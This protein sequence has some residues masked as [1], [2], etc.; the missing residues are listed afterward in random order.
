MQET[1]LLNCMLRTDVYP[2]IS[3][4]ERRALVR[5]IEGVGLKIGPITHSEIC[6]DFAFIKV[7]YDTDL[8]VEF[9]TPEGKEPA[10]HRWKVGTPAGRIMDITVN[11]A[12]MHPL[13][14]QVYRKHYSVGFKLRGHHWEYDRKRPIVAE[15]PEGLHNVYAYG[16]DIT[17][18][19]DKIV[20]VLTTIK[21]LIDNGVH[22]AK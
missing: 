6:A 18:F 11:V 2:E 10:G 5:M 20:T 8:P 19:E 14:E 4:A 22:V 15:L 1:K 9:W 7:D 12:W 16:E 13:D 21:S 3:D 17:D